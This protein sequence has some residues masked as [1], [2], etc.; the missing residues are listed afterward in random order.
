M[1]IEDAAYGLKFRDET[2]RDTFGLRLIENL[3]I[4][5]LDRSEI[6]KQMDEGI[7]PIYEKLG[8]IL[9]ESLVADYGPFKGWAALLGVDPTWE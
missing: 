2:A 3:G 5:Q 9:G 1:L 8:W 6:R 4:I 7:T